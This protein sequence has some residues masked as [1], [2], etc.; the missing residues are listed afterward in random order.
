LIK[1]LIAK[2][3]NKQHLTIAEAYQALNY[4]TGSEATDAQIAALL[5]ALKMK[6][7]TAEELTGFTSAMREKAIPIKYTANPIY[8]CC[9]TGGDMASTINV[10]TAAA[11]L[12][13]A[14]G[15][16]IAK[17][18]NRGVTSQSGSTDVLQ[19]L[20]IPVC[21]T[22]EQVYNQLDTNNIAFLHAPSFHQSTMAVAQIRKEISIR[23]IFNIL[24]PLSNP[25][26]PDGQL[27]GVSSP[28]LCQVVV[29]TLKNLKTKR[30]IIVCANKPRMDE[31]SICGESLIY[32]L[33]N[34]VI[35]SSEVT[36][37]SVGLKRAT[38]DQIKGSDPRTNAAIMRGIFE[39][40]IVDARRD[41]VLYNTAAIL[42]IAQKAEN[43]K[44]GVQIAANSLKTGK[45]YEKLFILQSE[46]NKS[47]FNASVE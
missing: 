15:V 47:L 46:D 26:L 41:I 35:T 22:P 44:E 18:S 21:T 38:I 3:S 43:L 2:V 14:C 30:A 40:K 6:G 13:S 42:W 10:S 17:H 16:Y 24:G 31:L 1:R 11:L 37:E 33:D 12:A 34:E 23:T 36:P 29:E 8:D 45:A 7:E 20:K 32:E 28:D 25:A 4:F 27:I 9:G 19:E 5:V 39:N